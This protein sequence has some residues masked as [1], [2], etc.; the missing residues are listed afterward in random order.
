MNRFSMSKEMKSD[1]LRHV[2]LL[3]PVIGFLLLFVGG[4]K[5]IGNVADTEQRKNLEAA[6]RRDIIQ[7]YALEGTYPPSLDYIEENY[8]FFYDV[9]KFY[10]DYT[11]VGANI[12]PDVTILSKTPDGY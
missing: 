3:V 1:R 5:F 11:A 10:I 8:G 12:M 9:D 4:T 2:L 7:C 6:L